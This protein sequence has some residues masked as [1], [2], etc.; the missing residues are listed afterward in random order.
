MLAVRGACRKDV[1]VV[2]R[3]GST[4]ANLALL[5][6]APHNLCIQAC[7]GWGGSVQPPQWE[8][9]GG[10][11]CLSVL[12]PHLPLRPVGAGGVVVLKGVPTC[13]ADGFQLCSGAPDSVGCQVGLGVRG[14]PADL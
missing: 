3:G 2:K 6:G 10:E 11:V 12:T 4:T 9:G 14:G 1:G 13:G 5:T 7:T 8:S